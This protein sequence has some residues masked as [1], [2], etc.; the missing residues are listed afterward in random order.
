MADTRSSKEIQREERR[1]TGKKNGQKQVE[2]R[3]DTNSRQDR[4]RYNKGIYGLKE[5][6]IPI[7]EHT[8]TDSRRADTYEERIAT[9]RRKIRYK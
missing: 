9:D 4:Y 8:D 1:D 3:T 2:E 6:Q 5:E 7:E